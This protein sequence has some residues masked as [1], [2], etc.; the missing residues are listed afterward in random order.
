MLETRSVVA[1]SFETHY[2]HASNIKGNMA[3]GPDFNMATSFGA[4]VVG[5]LFG[6]YSKSREAGMIIMGNRNLGELN[7]FK[8]QP[9]NPGWS[10]LAG[11]TVPPYD[12]KVGTSRTDESLADLS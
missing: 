3:T 10:A 5:N 4:Y 1:S 12:G 7:G 8:D 9:I 2:M 6:R 11:E